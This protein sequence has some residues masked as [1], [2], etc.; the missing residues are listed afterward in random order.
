VA[1]ELA[2]LCLLDQA[3]VIQDLYRLDLAEGWRSRLEEHILE[4]R[5]TADPTSSS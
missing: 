5:A 3:E 2:V 4:G 1:Q